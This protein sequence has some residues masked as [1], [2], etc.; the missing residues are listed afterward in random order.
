MMR[1]RGFPARAAAAIAWVALL[2]TGCAHSPPGTTGAHRP[3]ERSGPFADSVTAALWRLDET[4][5]QR[6]AD[7]GPFRLEGSAGIDT[8]TDFGRIRG[9]RVF[10]RSIDSFV[11]VP[12][13]PVLESAR[14][15]TV[16]A[17][18]Y[19]NAYGQYEDTPIAVR[20]TERG[21]EQ[22]WM[23]S[24]LG[25]N[26]LPPFAALA[27]PGYHQAFIQQG[28]RG[29]LMFVF[30][31]EEAGPPRAF[32][33]SVAIPLEKWT[34]V[35]ATFD[36]GLV[37]FYIDGLLDS[38]FA[39][40]GA[41]RSTKA[42]LLMGNYFDPRWLSDF[43]GDLRVA[44]GYDANPYYAFEGLIDELRISNVARAEFESARWR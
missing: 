6:V 10:S 9:A 35:A 44:P 25:L 24:V 31:P 5:G 21:D 42:A 30:Q 36:G 33:S 7:A 34:H 15:L 16:E 26:T 22:S 32:L 19:L 13:N 43:G 41:I 27:G 14:G 2:A 39:T 20:W 8:R 4:G 3:G 17:W 38:Q 12:F 18:I 28:Q 29:Q 23:F 40:V 11:F 1:P 37:R